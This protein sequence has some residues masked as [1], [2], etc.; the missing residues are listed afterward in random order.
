MN[1]NYDCIKNIMVFY[2]PWAMIQVI[3]MDMVPQ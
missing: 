1:L 2:L 3:N